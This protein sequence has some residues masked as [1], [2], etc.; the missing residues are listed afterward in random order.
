MAFFPGPCVRLDA[1]STRVEGDHGALSGGSTVP[2]RPAPTAFQ[3][4][5]VQ[6]LANTPRT[7]RPTRTTPEPERPL[8]ETHGHVRP[9]PTGHIGLYPDNCRWMVSCDVV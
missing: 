1:G 8:N 7:R 9:S 2:S 3:D 5:Y 6:W 4:W